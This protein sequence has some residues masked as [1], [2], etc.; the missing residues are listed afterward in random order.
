[1][2]VSYE[3]FLEGK[4]RKAQEA[5]RKIDLDAVSPV[6]YDWQARVVRWAIRAG[7]AALFEDCGLGK[8]GQQLEW[9]RLIAGRSLILAPLSVARQT[10]REAEHLLGLEVKYVRNGEQAKGPGIFVTNYEMVDHFDPNDF[11]A[12]VCD[13]ASIMKNAEA[14]TR[15]ALT[16]FASR[17]PYRLAC[18]A[19]PAPNDHAELTNQAAFLG[20]MS[21]VEMLAA[22]YVHDDDGWR[23]KG[24]ASG[25]MYKWMASWAVALRTPSDIGG[26]DAGFVLPKL[27]IIP[28]V[29][30]VDIDSPGQLF[31]ADLGGVGG[32]HNVRRQTIDA[33]CERGA[34]LA[35]QD[36]QWIVWAG[37]NEEADRI[38][39]DV[40]GA[41]NVEG[42]M[43][44]ERKAELLEAFQDGEVRVLV[45]KAKIAGFGMNFQ[46]C[47]QMAFVGLSDSYEAYYQAI[48]RC[49]RYG[50]T[51]PVN[52]HVVVSQLETQIID[53]VRRKEDQATEMTA[54]LVG[55]MREEWDHD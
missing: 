49:W 15:K 32:R 3:S 36:G 2:N 23:L 11:G 52:A 10:V 54:A 48:R 37:L 24:H 12:V 18:S 55:A 40:A 46:N 51:L 26:S 41:V 16:A 53:N 14:A 17:V 34:D 20:V 13:E 6:L 30:N 44:P 21:R 29:V 42:S 9:A 5:G 33:R 7:R 47:H 39:R 1:M 4:R 8:T 45:T 38:T 25:P 50:Q 35:N 28:E 27:S 43:A 31:A 22:Y 19:T